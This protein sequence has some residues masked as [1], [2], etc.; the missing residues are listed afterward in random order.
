MRDAT[1]DNT[2]DGLVV[3]LPFNEA[4]HNQPPSVKGSAMSIEGAIAVQRFGLGARPGEIDIA[5]RDPKQW[6]KDQLAGP[7]DQPASDTRLMSGSEL[8]IDAEA[9]RQKQKALREARMDGQVDQEAQ[10]ALYKTR[11]DLVANEMSA[12]FVQGFTTERPFAERL[13]WFWSNHFAVSTAKPECAVFAGAFEREVIR[14]NIAGSFEDMVQTA[15][16]HP[17]MLL[18]LDN[19]QSIGPG[20]PAG[21]KSGKGLNENLGRELMEL[22]T[23]GVDGGYTQADVIAMAKLLTGFGIDNDGGVNGFRFYPA[24]HEPG[25]ETLRGRTYPPG[26]DGA[27]AAIADLAKD[28]ATARHIARKFA[29]AFI[30]DAPH[31]TSVARLE[32]AFLKTNGNLR[33]LAEAAIDDPHAWSPASEK[34]RSPVEY[35]TAA[36]RLLNLPRLGA[37]PDALQRQVRGA[38]GGARLMGEFPLA[39][40][41]PKGWPLESTAWSGPDAVLNRIEWARQIAQRVPPTADVIRIADQGLGPLARRETLEAMGRA[42]TKGEAVALLL[43]SPEFQRR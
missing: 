17:A 16:R 2:C 11:A 41:S 31:E 10:K 25:S 35:V 15:M 7:A 29:Q 32:H 23:L 33:A 1:G 34:M 13:V 6:L 3:Q 30:A 8:V 37:Q 24:R 36:Y 27:T 39:A 42:A 12:R 22:Y 5:S 18:Y 19:A 26:E 40:P 20:S 9:F 21:R 43:V 38:M 28:P 4:N 14:P